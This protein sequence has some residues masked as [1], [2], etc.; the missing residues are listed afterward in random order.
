LPKYIR[1]EIKEDILATIL[2]DR[3]NELTKVPEVWATQEKNDGSY[4]IGLDKIERYI[5]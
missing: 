4:R 2:Q 1:N 3:G 5:S